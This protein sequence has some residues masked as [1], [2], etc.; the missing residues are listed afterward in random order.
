MILYTPL[1][2]EDIFPDEG[3]HNRKFISYQGKT[4]CVDQL[5][6]G[7]YSLIQLL[8]TDPKDFLDPT[9]TPGSILP[10]IDNQSINYHS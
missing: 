2:Q 6:N 5:E 8:S 3:I 1:S 9:L 7:T 10:E 4:L